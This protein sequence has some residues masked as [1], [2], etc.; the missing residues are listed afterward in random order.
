MLKKAKTAFLFQ[1][2]YFVDCYKNR[3]LHLTFDSY[4][5]SN[6]SF[7]TNQ[8][9]EKE[10]LELNN[11]AENEPQEFNHHAELY[12]VYMMAK[13]TT[14]SEDDCRFGFQTIARTHQWRIY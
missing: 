9:S 7:I 1:W 13:A 10:I 2:F 11:W 6:C 8:C 14:I 12:H 4:G 3:Q 5:T